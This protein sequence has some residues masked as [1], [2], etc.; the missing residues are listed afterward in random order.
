MSPPIYLIPCFLPV[1]FFTQAAVALA[2]NVHDRAFYE[3]KF[4]NWLS[5]FNVKPTNGEHFVKMLQN[6]ADNEDII[7]AHNS[8]NKSYTLGHNQFSHLSFAEFKE[9][10]HLGLTVPSLRSGEPAEF[11][12]RAPADMSTLADEIDWTLSGAVT[13]VKNQGSC[14]SCWSFSATGALE[15]AYKL[16]TGSLVS[17]SEQ[18]LVSCDRID[19]A[20]NGGWMDNAFGFVKRNGGLNSEENYR[21]TS[22]DGSVAACS[23]SGPLYGP[24]ASW[25]DLEKT[26]GALV[27]ALN[28]QPVS[29][30][31]DVESSFQLYASGVYSGPCG[32]ALNHGVLAVGYGSDFYKVKNSWGTTWGESGFIRMAR[33]N[34]C[35]ILSGPP[36]FPNLI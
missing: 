12:H 25:T 19:S 15:G 13:E 5:T 10:M 36:S 29:V 28:K 32:T 17:L 26:D 33:G 6:F 23:P 8:A 27:S 4:F 7:N 34:T 22:G 9:Q 35:G 3:A 24:V 14:G 20:C 16:K 30:A 11:I 21:Y 31:I 18:H 2:G 1:H